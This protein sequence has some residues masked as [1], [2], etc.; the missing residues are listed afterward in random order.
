[1]A[2]NKQKIMEALE[3]HKELYAGELAEITDID[4]SNISK[5]LNPLM[6]E[7]IVKRKYRQKGRTKYAYYSLLS[8][9]KRQEKKSLDTDITDITDGK[10]KKLY[11][12]LLKGLYDFMLEK[13]DIASNQTLTEE[14]RILLRKI[15]DELKK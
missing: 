9:K 5:Y 13:T 1:M 4:Q 2:T 12:R 6:S 3:E 14:D 11:F 8:V 10:D 7:G 15:E